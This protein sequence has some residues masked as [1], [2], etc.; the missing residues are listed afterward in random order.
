V[1]PNVQQFLGLAGLSICDWKFVESREVPFGP[2]LAGDNNPVV[3]LHP[4]KQKPYIG[5]NYE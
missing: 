2:W 1:S 5:K 3:L 4:Q